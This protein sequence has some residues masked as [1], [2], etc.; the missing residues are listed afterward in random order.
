[1]LIHEDGKIKAPASHNPC[2]NSGYFLVILEVMAMAI[3]AM[4][5]FQKAHQAIR[6]A[7][8]LNQ[9]HL[10]IVGECFSVIPVE[11]FAVC[12]LFYMLTLACFVDLLNLLLQP[13]VVKIE[14]VS[15]WYSFWKQPTCGIN[16]KTFS[17]F[18]ASKPSAFTRK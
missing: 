10:K 12:W 16:A 9:H 7:F 1:M 2:I 18:S 4:E 3:T 11:L 8:S 5:L 6:L 14:W 15:S 17:T 13:D